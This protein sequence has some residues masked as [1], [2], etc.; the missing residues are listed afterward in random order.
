MDETTH[1]PRDPVFEGTDEE[2]EDMRQ[3][4]KRLLEFLAEAEVTHGPIPQE[5]L[6]EIDAILD[7]LGE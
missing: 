1:V 5:Y 7:R 3:R 4:D 2:I 6:D